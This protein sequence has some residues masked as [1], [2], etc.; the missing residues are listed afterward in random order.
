MKRKIKMLLAL[1]CLTFLLA[2]AIPTANYDNQVLPAEY[3]YIENL[4]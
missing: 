4:S 2:T 3:T 1:F